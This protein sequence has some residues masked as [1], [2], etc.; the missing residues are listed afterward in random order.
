MSVRPVDGVDRRRILKAAAWSAPVI[1]VAV[2]AP[3]AAAS[4]APRQIVVNA[5]CMSSAFGFLGWTGATIQVVRPQGS[6]AP[7]QSVSVAYQAVLT[8]PSG[9][10]ERMLID[11]TTTTVLEGATLKIRSDLKWYLYMQAGT[12][13][14]TLT[15]VADGVTQVAQTTVTLTTPLGR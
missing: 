8:G 12:Y 6:T 7:A 5:G 11:W 15:A 4:V 13:T 2:A 9:F 3:A 1:A 14:L 10:R